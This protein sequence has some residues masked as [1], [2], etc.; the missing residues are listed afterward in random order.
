MRTID[1]M[2]SKISEENLSRSDY[3]LTIKTDKAGLLE[4]DKLDKC[5]KFG[6]KQTINNID[7]ILKL[8]NE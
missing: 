8:V 6:Y 2:G 7:K 3:V 4:I 1:V 5:Y